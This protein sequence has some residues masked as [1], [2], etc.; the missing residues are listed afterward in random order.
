MTKPPR[1]AAA[2]LNHLLRSDSLAGDLAE[3]FARGQSRI[4]YW[5][6]VLAA[7]SA[8]AW[9]DIRHHKLA[10]LGAITLGFAFVVVMFRFV[11]FRL[12]HF[13]ELLFATG[14]L[15]WFYTH[16]YGFPRGAVWPWA[17]ITFAASGWM[18]GRIAGQARLGAVVAYIFVTESLWCALGMWRFV[19]DPIPSHLLLAILTV[20]ARPV[21]A[22][23]AGL[24][25]RPAE[26]TRVFT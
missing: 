3:E 15:R 20:A 17:A 12:L 6:Q 21:P 19:Y 5:R 14:L 23:I 4:W 10:T 2:L 22:L 24:W 16:G 8:H 7:I 25:T 1:L 9:S 11:M 18:V 26:R 13:D